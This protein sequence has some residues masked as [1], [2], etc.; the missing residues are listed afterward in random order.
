MRRRKLAAPAT[1]VNAPG[2]P[3]RIDRAAP[4]YERATPLGIGHVVMFV[5]DVAASEE[6]Y[7]RHLGFHVSDRY[8]GAAVFLRC[9][10]EGGHHNLFLL[11]RRGKPGLTHVAF[12][13]RDIHEVF[14]GGLAMSRKGWETEIGPGRHP[15][16]S[17]YF[18]YFKSPCGGAAEYFADE[19]YLTAAWQPREFERKPENFVEW[20]ISGGIDG[21]TRRQKV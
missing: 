17:A 19:D 20:A 14:G 18:W 16:S 11:E 9:Q 15:I 3:L 13:V 7:V 8:P 10:A 21:K 1:P 12:T 6:F 2:A 4:L 5:A